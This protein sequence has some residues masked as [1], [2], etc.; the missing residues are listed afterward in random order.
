MLQCGDAPEMWQCFRLADTPSHPTCS[1]HLWAPSGP[2]LAESHEFLYLLT[3][4]D[5]T[6]NIKTNS[7]CFILYRDMGYRIII[8]CRISSWIYVLSF[9]INSCKIGTRGFSGAVDKNHE[10]SLLMF[11][12]ENLTSKFLL[13][14]YMVSRLRRRQHENLKSENNLRIIVPGFEIMHWL[15][16][17]FQAS[18]AM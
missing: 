17:W 11:Y 18:A 3:V 14:S 4:L 13:H 5:L 6:W 12:P 9:E 10:R 2:S 15:Y 1:H 16:A 8:R 7:S